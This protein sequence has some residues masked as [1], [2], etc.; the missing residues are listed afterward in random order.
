MHYSSWLKT[1][2][3]FLISLII[4]LTTAVRSVS[5]Q[6]RTDSLEALIPSL[7]GEALINT[8]SKLSSITAVVSAN[9]SDSLANLAIKLADDI[10]YETGKIEPLLVLSST[11]MSENKLVLAD[12]L[13]TIASDLAYKYNDTLGIVRAQVMAGV[14]NI[15]KGKL[16]EA[17]TNHFEG[18]ELSRSIGAVEMQVLHVINIGTIK[19]RLGDLDEAEGFFN[20]AL[21]LCNGTDLDYRKGQ[22]C[23]NLGLIYY[24]KGDLEKSIEYNQKALDAAIKYNE[25]ALRARSLN[26]LGFASNIKG[27]RQKALDYYDR[28]IKYR[29]EVN[30]FRG[31]AVV[32]LN[33][34][35][36]YEAMG[37]VQRVIAKSQEALKT[38]NERGE[39]ELQRDIYLFL[40]NFYD[41][42][43]PRKAFD[44]FKR[45]TGVKDSIALIQN[46]AR[47]D[48]LTA[49]YE[50]E[51]KEKNLEL[52][53]SNIELLSKEQSLLRT[54]LIMLMALSITAIA[55]SVVLYQRH[56]GK[57]KRAELLKKLAEEEA[58]AEQ[59]I[60]EKLEA[61]IESN[62]LRL[63]SYAEQLR[64]KNSLISGFEEKI[65][66][67]EEEKL[68]EEGMKEMKK[69]SE[70]LERDAENEVSWNDF[71]L[72]FEE[73]HPDFVAKMV[74]EFPA[75]TSYEL[76]L[77]I[78]LRLSLSYKEVSQILD[79]SYDS[80][81]KSVQR[82]Y[83]KLNFPSSGEFKSF[84]L[85]N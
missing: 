62:E 4:V 65:G 60:N 51:K 38:A 36:I 10:G 16:D 33:Q 7:E 37:D 22:I 30:D 20:E 2:R 56:K 72:K 1:K 71:K 9:K 79:I 83:R 19:Q 39:R 45:Y 24:Q 67:L 63:K 75:L 42:R 35:R 49:Q 52:A 3:A 70:A 48:E 69:W 61:K 54:R 23:L 57:V 55:I 13:F 29:I 11:R 31:I 68:K 50:L 26:N 43:D 15:R 44:N 32:K 47:V 64:F 80:V 12:S 84:V 53:Q 5:G 17:I 59:L 40:S 81:K 6:H 74:T 28:S 85:N 66:E 41:S 8:L 58:M 21:T 78:L 27:E 25:N 76:D 46:R 14:I 77:I 34:A 82:L 18:L 73:V